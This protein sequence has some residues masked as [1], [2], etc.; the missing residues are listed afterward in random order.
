MKYIRLLSWAAGASVAL[1][2]LGGCSKGD[3]GPEGT[4]AAV[5]PIRNGVPL[6]TDAPFFGVVGVTNGSL[7]FGTGTL[8]ASDWVLTAGHVTDKIK[9][10]TSQMRVRLG[11]KDDPAAQERSVLAVYLHPQHTPGGAQTAGDVDVA[12]LR[13]SSAFTADATIRTISTATTASLLN[14]RVTCYGYGL[15]S[16]TATTGGLL[17][18]AENLKVTSV[19]GNEFTI[20][21]NID[22]DL[23][24]QIPLQGDSGGACVNSNEDILGVITTGDT[25]TPAKIAT[26]D[27]AASFRTW[28]LGIMS[29]CSAL[30]PGSASFCNSTCPCPYGYG[31][32]D[33]SSQC[34]TSNV[35]DSNVGA[36][37]GLT[38]DS[39]VCVSSACSTGVI[40]SGTYCSAGC[41]C[42]YGGGDCDSAS[43]CQNGLTCDSNVGA[44]FGMTPSTDV[45]VPPA[46]AVLT[47]GSGNYCSAG[48]PCGHGGGDC[49]SNAQ[50]M[51]G[52]V[53]GTDIGPAF[54]MTSTTDVCVP[55]ACAAVELYSATFCSPGCP[56]GR[57]GGD[58]DSD[59]DCMPG[60]VCGTD[61][62]AE[63]GQS[64]TTDICVP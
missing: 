1:A 30:V 41:P 3:T 46:C 47:L 31:D 26:L 13:L 22:P 29:S 8:V 59:Q 25:V 21:E 57:G 9:G 16:D 15:T 17:T 42:G 58:C 18:F 5:Q 20:T 60:L 49:D 34:S 51:P 56:C 14:T 19:N 64:A 2:T 44:G 63:F 28:A 33:S 6:G 40:G 10:N 62:G 4:D 23:G 55:A 48:C 53:C 50:C 11:D 12:L 39:D 24:S 35:C 43:D 54:N 37:F 45:C 61:N 36:A 32:C 52:L 27:G 38:P 7:S